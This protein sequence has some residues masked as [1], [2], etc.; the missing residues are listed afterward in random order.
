MLSL[1]D[2]EPDS[3]AAGKSRD[4]NSTGTIELPGADPQGQHWRTQR[5]GGSTVVNIRVYGPRRP[6]K[7]SF[8]VATVIDGADHHRAAACHG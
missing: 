8:G 7:D 3:K 5:R 6:A 1:K 2:L 4:L